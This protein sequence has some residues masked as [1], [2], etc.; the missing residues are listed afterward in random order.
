MPTTQQKTIE[1]GRCSTMY[2]VVHQWADRTPNAPAIAAVDTAPLTY[3]GLLTL[4]DTTGDTLNASGMGRGNRIAIVHAGGARLAAV[5]MSISSFATAVPLNPDYTVGEFA[6]YFQDIGIDAVA[7][8]HGSN[9]AA[10]S[11]AHRLGIPILEILPVPGTTAGAFELG[12]S[13]MGAARQPGPADKDDIA[14]VLTTSGT[15]SSSKIV[16]LRHRHKIARG[17]D[18]AIRFEVTAQDRVLNM[19]PLFHIGGLGAGLHNMLYSGATVIPTPQLDATSFFEHLEAI[20]PTFLMGAYTIYHAIHAQADRFAATISSSSSQIRIIRSGAGRLDPAVAHRLEDI[21][22]AP[23]IQA[24][25]STETGFMASEPLPPKVRKPGSVGLPAINEVAILNE[26]G[27]TLGAGQR[28]EVAIRGAMITD[29]YENDPEANAMAFTN[30][31][32]RTGDE[33]YFDPDGYLFLTGRLKEMIN[34]GGQKIAPAEIDDALMSHPAVAAGSAFAVPH[35]TL[36]DEV[37]AAVV[38]KPGASAK[39]QTLSEF[40]RQRLA[41]YKVPR[42]FVFVDD[43]PK[44]STGKVQRH[45]LTEQLGLTGEP[46]QVATTNRQATPLE[47]KLQALWASALEREHV[48]LHE[49]FF[50]LGGDSLQ[51]IELFLDIEKTLGRRLPRSVL[52]EAGTVAEM[53]QRI[54]ALAPM[55]CLVPIRP[56]G[57][58]PIFFCIHD[59]FGEVLI[60]RALAEHLGKDQPVFGLQSV[61]LDG[62]ETPLARMEDMAARY[63]TEIRRVQPTGPYYLGGYSMGGWIAYEMARQLRAAEESVGLLALFDTHSGQGRR[64]APVQHWLRRHTE[65]L[66]RLGPA[67]LGPYLTQ[68]VRN[69]LHL[70]SAALRHRLFAAAWA[71]NERRGAEM[72][73][74]L[75][76][77]VDANRLAGRRYHPRPYDGDAVLFKAAPY[78][79]THSDAHDGWRRLINGK[80]EVR[81]ITGLHS[82]ILEEPHVRVLAREL[83]DCLDARHVAD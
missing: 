19:M 26:D 6:I 11:A 1:A 52:F 47:K 81:Q 39:E 78:A 70:S 62:L 49:N 61:G 55:R 27:E 34:R 12:C 5:I 20:R 57:S 36:G 44:G 31:W 50:L 53:A 4:I 35:P 75:Q 13:L 63:V 18:T 72:P 76:R 82:E 68:R 43:I 22:G 58:R 77:P 73:L 7:I 51:A 67:E 30:G 71:Y 33:G 29:G 40:L 10:R 60:F 32:Y 21:F 80:L 56:S 37:A 3:R 79:W 64:R 14:I 28:G 9:A 65:R 66:S 74:L 69:A 17:V 38:L 2:E 25:G 16:P 59:V 45:R 23:V 48:G 54:E 8:Q 24:Y 83:A 15:T 46:A 42:R 41:P